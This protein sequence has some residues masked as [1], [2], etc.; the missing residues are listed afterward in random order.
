MTPAEP[1]RTT[2]RLRIILALV[3]IVTTM[4][5][6]LAYGVL[7]IK[8][9]LEATVLADTVRIQ[10]VDL[11]QQREAGD[12]H[13]EHLFENW[14][15][16]FDEGLADMPAALRELGP[17]SHHSAYADGRY[18]QV[19]VGEDSAGKPL[20]LAY[21][22]TTWER[23]EHEVLTLL[24]WGVVLQLLVAILLGWQA[25]RAILAPVRALTRRLA[26]IQPN[27]RQV[28]IAQ[29]FQGTEIGIIAGE[30]DQYLARLDRFVER[31]RSFTAAAS[32]ELRTP[33]SVMIGALDILDNA[34][35]SG[36]AERARSRIHRACAEMKAFIEATLYLS[37][38]DGTTIQEQHSCALRPLIDDL[39]DSH[40]NA[41]QARHIV[42]EIQES[43]AVVVEQ[44]PSLM[45]ILL[46]NLLRNAIEHTQNGYLRIS[47]TPTLIM[48]EDSGN[49]IPREDL[50]R[51]FERS[52]TTK[53]DGYGLG[54]NLVK[55][56]CDRV[57]WQVD[58]QSEV[59]KGTQVRL[60]LQP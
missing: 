13:V 59:G 40:Q 2:L 26:G 7:E 22:I 16:Y 44:A 33:L 34:P 24:V 23:Q 49:G 31:E 5:T 38:E 11:Q 53:K 47:F 15:F 27:Q 19:E 4:S 20:V 46:G 12:Y 28:R 18:Y 10:L 30:F 43:G 37:R 21:D 1:W 14:A 57:G 52:Y 6:L 8:N 42:V 54:L 41:L 29:D 45:R 25:S 56:I 60:F 36:P 58:I 39:I 32:H 17:G 51:V 55:R 35:L 3:L 9:R 48:V 50:P